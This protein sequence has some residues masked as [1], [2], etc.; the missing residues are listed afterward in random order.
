M[1]VRRPGLTASELEAVVSVYMPWWADHVDEDVIAW[2]GWQHGPDTAKIEALG[3]S[4]QGSHVITPDGV[5]L[6]GIDQL[7]LDGW[8][9]AGP[10]HA[11]GLGIVFPIGQLES[12]AGEFFLFKATP[13]AEWVVRNHWLESGLEAISTTDD[14]VDP[15]TFRQWLSALTEAINSGR[16]TLGEYG[17]IAV[18][19]SGNRYTPQ[20]HY[21]W[22]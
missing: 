2:Y 10:V 14:T 6:A 21:P 20:H 1:E 16:L 18:P 13:D 9:I 8:E 5:A 22:R 11:E 4:S 7:L 15:P 12:T 19:G 3:I 17:E